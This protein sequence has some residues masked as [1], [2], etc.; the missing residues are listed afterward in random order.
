MISIDAF[1]GIFIRIYQREIISSSFCRRLSLSLAFLTDVFCADSRAG[2]PDFRA[3][4]SKINTLI[5]GFKQ[6]NGKPKNLHYTQGYPVFL[7]PVFLRN[8]SILNTFFQN[9][10][11]PVF[12]TVAEFS[13]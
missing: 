4:L 2:F 10:Q 12:L 8:I 6:I 1:E 11:G 7:T 9:G 3:D 5:W 13:I